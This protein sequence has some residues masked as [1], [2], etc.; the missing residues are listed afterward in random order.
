MNIKSVNLAMAIAMASSLVAAAHPA[1]A[2]EAGKEKCFGI[3]LA[4][5]NDC[6]A[7]GNNSCAGTSK[8]DYDKGA[9][10]YVPAGTCVSTEV[11]LKDGTKRMGSLE[12][13]KG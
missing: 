9:W 11:T 10:K 12:P 4:G 2:E 1:K 5:K 7:T 8:R 13:I 3:A 6:A